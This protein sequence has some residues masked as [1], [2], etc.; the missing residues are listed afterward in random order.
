MKEFARS[1]MNFLLAH[2]NEIY[3]ALML[4]VVLILLVSAVR[5]HQSRGDFSYE[6]KDKPL[7]SRRYFHAAYSG[8]E[9]VDDE[10]YLRYRNQFSAEEV[11]EDSFTRLEYL[12]EVYCPRLI[13][14][15]I[16]SLVLMALVASPYL[17]IEV[18][19]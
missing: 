17:V 16:V 18:F 8:G 2:G 15:C 14:G 4:A 6:K 7:S 3:Y 19:A 9:E 13:K 12:A 11:D 10:D 5:A 1:A